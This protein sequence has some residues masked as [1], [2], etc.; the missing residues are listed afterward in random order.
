MSGCD[1]SQTTSLM[2]KDP[3][4]YEEK[5]DKISGVKTYIASAELLDESQP[6]KY[7]NT[8]VTCEGDD[9]FIQTTLHTKN[10][11]SDTQSEIDVTKSKNGQF[12]VFR[13]RSGDNKF[14]KIAMTPEFSNKAILLMKDP[15][16]LAALSYIFANNMAGGSKKSVV[17]ELSANEL[18]IE[19]PSKYG[20]PV[21][22]IS[23]DSPNVQKIFNACGLTPQYMKKIEQSKDAVT[24]PPSDSKTS[25]SQPSSS[26][27]NEN[28]S[29]FSCI[30]EKHTI[31]INKIDASNYRYRSWNKPKATDEKPDMDLISK[32]IAT[33]GTGQC[34]STTYSF[35]T[36]N[37]QI[38][39]DDNTQ[40]LEGKPPENISGNLNVYINNQLKNHYYCLK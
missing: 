27:A 6:Q 7:V 19:I 25:A 18:F 38:H 20:S 35:T 8:E 32:D 16:S 28:Q 11:S 10:D 24:P 13:M 15:T 29:Q 17:D 39:V 40:C 34:R 31:L 26:S 3:W 30:T 9:M 23:L 2:K 12:A 14:S 36:G 1:K 4:S 22:S 37:V 33:D 21:I 5:V